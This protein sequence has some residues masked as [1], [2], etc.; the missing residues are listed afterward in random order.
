MANNGYFATLEDAERAAQICGVDFQV[1][2]KSQ[3]GGTEAGRIPDPFEEP[4]VDVQALLHDMGD[5][6]FSPDADEFA[7]F[8]AMNRKRVA[9]AVPLS[10]D[11]QTMLVLGYRMGISAGSAACMNDLGA[12][13]YMG[14][15]VEQ[16]YSKAAE[17]YELAMDH[18]CYQSII[19]LG[20][21]W[22]YG[23]TGTCDHQKAYRYFALAAA[24]DQSS[25]AVYKL[26]DMYARGQAVERDMAKAYQLWKRSLDLAEGIVEIAQPA[27]RIA[28][29]LVSEE[30]AGAAGIET[31]PLQ[32]LHLF[33]QAEVGLRIDIDN[34]QTYYRK[35]LEEAIE[36]QQ[37]ARDLLDVVICE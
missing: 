16:D 34:G 17:L 30:D 27:V 29:L 11:V 6:A 2:D 10:D 13:Y 18:G 31:D 12:L 33:Q 36:G 37:A 23:R 3:L 25:E 20:Y 21:I 35:R 5:A 22:E 19:N 28:Q 8:V 4:A 1:V 7:R 32:A 26:G 24:L 9:E 15:L 14:D